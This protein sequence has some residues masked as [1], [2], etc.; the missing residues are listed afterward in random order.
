MQQNIKGRDLKFGDLVFT[1][2]RGYWNILGRAIRMMQN[3]GKHPDNKFMPNHVGIIIKENDDI[4]EIGIIQSAGWGVRIK[5]LGVWIEN[6][7]SNLLFR[8]YKKPF[9]KIQKS[10]LLSWLK[11]KDG[12]FYDYPSIVATIVKYFVMEAF[13][14]KF[15]KWI[16]KRWK[17][18]LDSP[19]RFICSEL[20]FKAWKN[21]MGVIICPSANP[22][23]VSPYDEMRSKQFRTIGRYYN[24]DYP[25]NKYGKKID[26]LT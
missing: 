13:D 21:C 23:D 12:L 24:Y 22:S 9:T 3:G 1:D 10:R 6:S 25:V 8:R 18:P 7:Q 11:S 20:V 2:D 4:N 16:I 26:T 19:T 5:K 14:N 15:I 17:N